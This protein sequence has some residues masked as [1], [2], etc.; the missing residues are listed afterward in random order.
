[1]KSS[2]SFANVAHLPLVKP[3]VYMTRKMKR[4]NSAVNSFEMVDIGLLLKAEISLL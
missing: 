4:N 2:W 1:M 3:K